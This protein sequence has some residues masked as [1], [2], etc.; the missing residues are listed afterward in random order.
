M[1]APVEQGAVSYDNASALHHLPSA[2][3]G[4]PQHPAEQQSTASLLGARSPKHMAV[5]KK[6][7]EDQ[8]L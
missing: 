2:S 4:E 6:S 8:S 3:Q 7:N 1:K 5:P